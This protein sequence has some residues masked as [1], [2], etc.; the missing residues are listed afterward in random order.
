[1]H[2]T[3]LASAAPP[4]NAGESQALSPPQQPPWQ[5]PPQSAL[6]PAQQQPLPG[7]APQQRPWSWT[8]GIQQPAA[9]GQPGRASAVLQQPLWAHNA[10]VLPPAT[11]PH[12]AW[13]PG[14]QQLLPGLASP[15]QPLWAHHA[16][17]QQPLRACQPALAPALQRQLAPG[18]APFWTPN[19]ALQQ[20]SAA[21]PQPAPVPPWAHYLPSVAP[22]PAGLSSPLPLPLQA[23]VLSIA[24]LQL[25]NSAPVPA[26]APFQLPHALHNPAPAQQSPAAAPD[27]C[28]LSC[29]HERLHA[30]MG[31]TMAQGSVLT[32][33]FACKLTWSRWR[34]TD[35]CVHARCCR[36]QQQTPKGKKRGRPR[37]QQPVQQ[38]AQ[39]QQP[40]ARPQHQQRPL[41]RAQPQ[42]P[43]PQ[44]QPQQLGM[45][46]AQ[47]RAS[48][49]VR[50]QRTA[51]SSAPADQE[52]LDNRGRAGSWLPPR[53]A[54]NHARKA[55]RAAPVLG[56]EQEPARASAFL[57]YRPPSASE[58]RP[59]PANAPMQTTA[60]EPAAE[61]TVP[62]MERE[63]ASSS[64]AV[65]AQEEAQ[66]GGGWDS[67]GFGSGGG[68]DDE[69]HQEPAG[70]VDGVSSG[71]AEVQPDRPQQAPAAAPEQPQ[72]AQPGTTAGFAFPAGFRRI[73]SGQPAGAEGALA[74][75]TASGTSV[76]TAEGVD[77]ALRAFGGGGQS[78]LPHGSALS[79]LGPEANTLDG[80]MR[81]L[82]AG[83]PSSAAR[84]QG[85][86][87][88]ALHRSHTG[89][90]LLPHGMSL[91]G[92]EENTLDGHMRMLSSQQAPAERQGST[93][94]ATVVGDIARS[95]QAPSSPAQQRARSVASVDV[96]KATRLQQGSQPLGTPGPAQ[97]HVH[98][99]EL[100]A[101][102]PSAVLAAGGTP[103]AETPS[104][105]QPQACASPPDS[106]GATAA[107]PAAFVRLEMP[108]D[109]DEEQEQPE[110][111]E[112]APPALPACAAERQAAVGD[113]PPAA[114]GGSPADASLTKAA[115]SD[116]EQV[117]DGVVTRWTR[118]GPSL[119][120]SRLR[121]L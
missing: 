91:L 58:R 57:P 35:A 21:A 4:V 55:L 93:F 62:Q 66:D 120:S 112:A 46:G 16:A 59:S 17:A 96:G 84:G 110:F 2:W 65:G 9:A 41:S 32:S 25:S 64:P 54:A 12:P 47:H 105:P 49:A 114:K 106:A 92:R 53:L 18:P 30:C 101:G 70:D 81:T 118:V 85:A 87:V 78:P 82:L 52:A 104:L 33:F 14:L 1:M 23:P 8:H 86:G 117:I 44:Q 31:L 111:T 36:Q 69:P 61:C 107:A 77:S 80:H 22:P 115:H 119:T 75:N 11:L 50:A 13:A 39:P 27:R 67:P 28:A 24:P 40:Q 116:A 113:R 43:Q 3:L 6:A 51:P 29:V 108:D 99:S 15:Q 71:A 26:L 7:L 90:S 10:A 121:A 68:D 45:S 5:A 37:K 34:V 95:Q 38:L 72:Q 103:E 20:Q 94:F 63:V 102:P 98:A 97:P 48:D 89:Q 19:V 42:P 73:A 60:P 76:I 109:S 88:A 56:G 83:Q 100:A 74:E 79:L